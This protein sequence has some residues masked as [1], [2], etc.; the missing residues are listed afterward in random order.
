MHDIGMTDNYWTTRRR[1]DRIQAK[2]SKQFQAFWRRDTGI[3]RTQL[4]TLASR[5]YSCISHRNVSTSRSPNPLLRRRVSSACV[6]RRL[7]PALRQEQPARVI[8]T[9]ESLG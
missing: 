8:H 1:R 3:E 9:D 6:V 7:R 5:Y 2:L 4:A